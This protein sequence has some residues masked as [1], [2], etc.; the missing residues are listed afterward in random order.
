MFY[1]YFITNMLFLCLLFNILFQDFFIM[2]CFFFFFFQAEDGIR[3]HAQSRG[4]GDVY[5]RQVSTQSTWDHSYLLQC[6]LQFNRLYRRTVLDNLLLPVLQLP[7]LEWSYLLSCTT[8]V[9]VSYTH[10]TLPTICSVQISV[11]A[12]SLKKKKKIKNHASNYFLPSTQYE[13]QTNED[14]V[15]NL[16]Q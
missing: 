16:A 12:V 6:D 8:I 4:L 7:Q 1:I 2:F 10:L 9:S 15:Q 3:D 14:S 5:K 11:V 13:P